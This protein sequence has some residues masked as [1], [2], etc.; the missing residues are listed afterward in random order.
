[1]PSRAANAFRK[2]NMVLLCG[3]N[4]NFSTAVVCIEI[5]SVTQAPKQLNDPIIRTVEHNYYKME[6]GLHPE[7]KF[8]QPPLVSASKYNSVSHNLHGSSFSMGI[9]Y[10]YIHKSG[11][12]LIYGNRMYSLNVRFNR[13]D[14][15]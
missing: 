8:K 6:K 10:A 14:K 15:M 3:T 11:R 2:T 1:M 5:H 13:L 4:H 9:A 7:M 12:Y